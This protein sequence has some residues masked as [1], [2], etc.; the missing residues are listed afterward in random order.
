MHYFL[1]DKKNQVLGIKRFDKNSSLYAIFNRSEEKLINKTLTVG[2]VNDSFEAKD[3]ISGEVYQVQGGKLFSSLFR[4]TICL[5][6]KAIGSCCQSKA[7][8][9]RDIERVD[10]SK[11]RYSEAN[12]RLYMRPL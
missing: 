10:L 9:N 12:N 1:I 2:S 5:T 7:S 4:W 3:L 11:H 6:A 8:C